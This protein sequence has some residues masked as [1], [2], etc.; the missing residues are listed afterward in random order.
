MVYDVS[1]S[2]LDLNGDYGS[3]TINPGIT[4]TQSFSENFKGNIINNGNFTVSAGNTTTFNGTS[5]Q[6]ISGTGTSIFN[7]LIITNVNS[8]TLGSDQNLSINGD[9]SCASANFINNNTIHQTNNNL[10]FNHIYAQ[11]FSGTSTNT[12]NNVTKINGGGLTLTI[13]SL[14]ILGV[15]ESQS[16]INHSGTKLVLRST[17]QNIAGMIKINDESNYVYNSGYVNVQRFYNSGV[18]DW[19]MIGSPIEKRQMVLMQIYLFGMMSFCT[20]DLQELIMVMAHVVTL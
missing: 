15:L 1:T 17:S 16:G 11:T 4:I 10:T 20:V 6:S 19:R 14:I 2:L 3:L 12:F 9:I 8:F 5:D 13:D 18:N 7:D